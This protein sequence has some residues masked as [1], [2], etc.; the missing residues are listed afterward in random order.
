ML[1]WEKINEQA[2]NYSQHFSE[3]VKTPIE[4]QTTY[5]TSL[6]HDNKNTD[7]GQQY[8]FASIKSVDDFQKVVPI[9]NYDSLE[10]YIE[11]NFQHSMPTLSH[12]QTLLFEKTSGSSGAAKIIPYNKFSLDDFRH[13]IYPWLHLSLIH[14]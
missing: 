11:N 9:Q 7:F 2:K 4:T 5:L 3:A 6:L 8:N 13:A 12:E 14:I 1:A 10:P